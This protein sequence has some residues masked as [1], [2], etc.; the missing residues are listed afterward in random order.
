[1]ST[2]QLQIPYIEKKTISELLKEIGM[3]PRL[4][5]FEYIKEAIT[6][7]YADASY[8]RSITKQMYPEIAKTFN[9]TPSRVERAMR[10]AIESAWSLGNC[11]KQNEIFSFTIGHDKA[12]PTN[13]EFIACVVEYLHYNLD[14]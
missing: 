3:K 2:I 5:G 1:M 12:K 7:C 8:M 11:Y 6:M 4:S 14:K 9:T 13:G 10:H